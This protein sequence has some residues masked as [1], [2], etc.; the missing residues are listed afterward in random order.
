MNTNYL[1]QVSLWKDYSTY[2]HLLMI[3]IMMKL[4]VEY[5]FELY[6][7]L[8]DLCKA[9]K[10]VEHWALLDTFHAQIYAWYITFETYV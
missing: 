10:I 7:P 3:W 8:V 9:L 6:L 5:N 2:E 4:Y 1:E